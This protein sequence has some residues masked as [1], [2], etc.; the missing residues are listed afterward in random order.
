MRLHVD[1]VVRK[2]CINRG[3]LTVDHLAKKRQNAKFEMPFGQMG[4]LQQQ[5]EL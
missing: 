2:V 5:E 1:N 4:A 3:K